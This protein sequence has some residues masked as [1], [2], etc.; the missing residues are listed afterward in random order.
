MVAKT[1]SIHAEHGVLSFHK[2]DDFTMKY[3]FGKI[4]NGRISKFVLVKQFL[5]QE[6][7]W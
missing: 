1:S 3:S 6:N 2:T 4:N 7:Y 5:L